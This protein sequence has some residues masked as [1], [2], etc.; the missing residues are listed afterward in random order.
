MPCCGEKLGQNRHAP[1]RAGW[2][3]LA[4]MLVKKSVW[5]VGGDGWAYD[6]GYGGSTTCWRAAGNVNVLVLDTEVYS[7]T[8]G[9]CSKATPRGAVAKFAAGGKPMGKKDLA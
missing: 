6:I 1:R 5:I 2:A 7:N 4:D 9:Q 3:H 8:G